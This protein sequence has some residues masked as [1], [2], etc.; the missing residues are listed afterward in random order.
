[1]V[2]RSE[3]IYHVNYDRVVRDRFQKNN[4]ERRLE[5]DR[6]RKK[7]VECPQ[8]GETIS[9][10]KWAAHLRSHRGF[11]KYETAGQLIW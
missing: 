8:C 11:I 4:M 10:L 1:M 5:Y 7:K 2:A 6:W 3:D 9:T